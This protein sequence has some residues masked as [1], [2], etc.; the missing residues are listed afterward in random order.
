MDALLLLVDLQHDFLAADGL[1]PH[2]ALV[3]AGAKTLLDAFRA[4]WLACAHARMTVRD[5]PDNRMPHWVSAGRWSCRDGSAGHASP[6]DLAPQGGEH[7]LEKNGFSAFVQPEL[8][9]CLRSLQPRRIVVAG[10]HTHTCVR[11]TAIDAYQAGYGV[12]IAGE[13][14]ASCEP[15][16]AAQT[17]SYLRRRGIETLPTREILDRLE[18]RRPSEPPAG[19]R[20][21]AV[22]QGRIQLAGETNRWL[23]HYAPAD[24][25]ALRWAFRAASQGQVDEA[26]AA[27]ARAAQ[28]TCGDAADSIRWLQ[29]AAS[30]I[31]GRSA[32]LVEHLVADVGKPIRYARREVQRA[33]DLLR[34]VAG[35]LDGHAAVRAETEAAV[36]RLPLGAVAVITPWNNPLAIPVGEIAPALAYGNSVVWKPAPAGLGM[37]WELWRLLIEAGCPADRLQLVA[38]D[39]ETGRA[40]VSHPG[41]DAVSFTGSIASGWKL[42]QTCLSQGKRLRAELG[43]NNAA[44]VDLPRTDWAQA[45][46]QIAEA[47]FAFAGQRCTATRRVIALTEDYDDFV[48]E[49]VRATSAV[50]WGAADSELTH[51][52][53]LLSRDR[54]DR[55]QTAVDRAR[56]TG[57][58]VLQPAIEGPT[59]PGVRS[60]EGAWF[61]PT[62][63]LCDDPRAEIVQ[64]ESFAPVLVVQRAGDWDE[65]VRL[66]NGVHHG[67]V[68]TLFSHDRGRRERFVRVARAGIVRVHRPTA[69]PGVDVPFGGWKASGLGWPQHGPANAE[70]FTRYQT[71]Y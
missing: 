3:E 23:S 5:D 24:Q 51:A 14:V 18:G 30:L 33:S 28:G 15:L 57:C 36:G 62:L 19:I 16:E 26:V 17:E 67:L 29:R 34:A 41:I 35:R 39:D 11:Q 6:P 8:L 43:G 1:E 71:V 45:A 46:R 69:E 9:H 2:R 65:A 42:A 22:T 61:P 40:V 48:A 49:L 25:R 66:A 27:A 50:A 64:V 10:V 20:L 59:D 55:T 56:A 70:F 32:R 37:G 54:V 52:G 60:A 12:W 38:G 53:P 68:A 58:P 63:V 13:A 7:V 4:R 21:S 44:V 47:A 31:E